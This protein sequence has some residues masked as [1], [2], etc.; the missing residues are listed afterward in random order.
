[1]EDQYI[2]MLACLGFTFAP[3]NFG[4]CAGGL[5]AISQNN[6]LF[7]LIGTIYGGDG[8]TTFGLPDLR[9][10]AAISQGR[11]P[12]SQFNW[13]AGQKISQETHTLSILEMPSH[14]HAASLAGTSVAS[15]TDVEVSTTQGTLSVP[16]SGDY[17]GAGPPFG[18]AQPA[19]V[20]SGSEGTTVPL[21]GVSTNS[22]LV[23]GSVTIGRTGG[24]QSFS[25]MQP[26]Q[27][28]NWCICLFG[29]YPSRS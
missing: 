13:I 4:F 21:G 8:R 6:A 16:S 2:G 28:L 10:R 29:L 18:A 26:V 1:M 17:I 15:S 25:I 5:V 19:Y 14:D 12:G 23:G 22:A 11:F 24:S 9:G 3:R 20:P 27:A 7:S